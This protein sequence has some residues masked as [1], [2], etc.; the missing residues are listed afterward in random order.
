IVLYNNLVNLRNEC[1]RAFSNIDVL[2][3]QRTDELANL[4][5]V[6]KAYMVHERETLR[7]V[8]QARAAAEAARTPA[9]AERA[10]GMVA[11]A[12]G[13]LFALAESYPD[14][15]AS[16]SFRMLQKRITGIENEIADRREFFN[17][18]VTAWNTRVEQF[19]DALIAGPFLK[20]R[21]RPLLKLAGIGPVKVDLAA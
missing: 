1:D 11:G 21:R 13:S 3:R 20:G 14:L 5:E 4:V 2:L 6:V 10:A 15:A 7:D 12:M 9:E 19:P 16:S 18:A 17:Q 8:A